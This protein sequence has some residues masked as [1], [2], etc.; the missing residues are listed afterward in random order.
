MKIIKFVH[1]EEEIRATLVTL[2]IP[3]H[4]PSRPPPA[5]DAPQPQDYLIVPDGEPFYDDEHNAFLG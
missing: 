5:T 1:K 3:Y 4:D 2:G